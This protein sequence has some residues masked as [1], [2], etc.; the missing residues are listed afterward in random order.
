MTE[1]GF[2]AVSFA[3]VEVINLNAGGNTLSVAAT[4]GDDSM[5][6]TVG[7][8]ASGQIQDGISLVR[9]GQPPQQVIVPPAINYTNIVGGRVWTLPAATIVW[10]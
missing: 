1:A 3:G 7:G 9:L 5:T 4:P 6:V 8:A 2:G 10:P